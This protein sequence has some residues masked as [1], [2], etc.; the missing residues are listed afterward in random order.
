MKFFMP[1]TAY[2]GSFDSANVRDRLIYT[3]PAT[4]KLVVRKQAITM[5]DLRQFIDNHMQDTCDATNA[6]MG[7]RVRSKHK[8]EG[9]VAPKYVL[10]TMEK[11]GKNAFTRVYF[12]KNHLIQDCI[13]SWGQ[14]DMVV[15]Q[16]VVQKTLQA[17]MYRFYRNER[18]V[19][20]AEC[21]INGRSIASDPHTMQGFCD[22][23]RET[24]EENSHREGS[25]SMMGSY[26][27]MNNSKA[28]GI[29]D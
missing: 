20:R 26:D 27:Q 22:L 21:I 16:Y 18:N 10:K 29:T 7:S 6:F 13:D 14:G 23:Y 12:D 28:V 11:F 17:C 19:F 15:Q 2:I 4:F 25:G 5:Q 24:L 8:D 1:P 3:D 9:I